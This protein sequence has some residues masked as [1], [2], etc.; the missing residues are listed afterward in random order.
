MEELSR[1]GWNKNRGKL[2]IRSELSGH[3]QDVKASAKAKQSAQ[4]DTETQVSKPTDLRSQMAD[5]F[6]QPPAMHL[7]T[8]AI[9]SKN[10]RGTHMVR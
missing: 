10:S 5:T 6:P 9:K 8:P 7:H 2:Q 1:S 3:H 4:R